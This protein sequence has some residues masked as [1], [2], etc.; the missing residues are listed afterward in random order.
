MHADQLD[1]DEGLVRRLLAE[2]FPRWRD[3]PVRLLAADG[4]VNTIFRVGEELSARFP[5][6]PTDPTAA[7]VELAREAA[8]M[9]QLAAVCPVP[10][11]VPVARGMP[12]GGYPLPWSVQTWIAGAVCTPH[13]LA[14][15]I[16]F[17]EDLV[18]LICSFRSVDTGGRR[19]SRAGRGGDLRDSDDWMEIC[20]RES[21]GLLPVEKLRA[22]W[23]RFR[24]LPPSG[25]DVMTH[26]DL[27]PSNLLVHDGRLVGVLDGGGFAPADPALDLVAAWHLLDAEARA[28]LRDGLDVGDL[29]WC[30]GTAWAFQ[31]AMGLVWYYRESNAAMSGLG[32]STLTRILGDGEQLD[33]LPRVSRSQSTHTVVNPPSIT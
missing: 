28:V 7:A 1:V 12:G 5:L 10:T 26:G 24:M 8:A 27:T 18:T 25:P 11:P 14:D 6:N 4:T 21:E 22:L 32:R 29:E 15:S 30:R 9:R 33:R 23:E 19:F 13:G 31:Q 3:E 17:A 16:R 2:Q 20:F